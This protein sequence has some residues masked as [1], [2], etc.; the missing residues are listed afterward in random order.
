MSSESKRLDRKLLTVSQVAEILDVPEGY[1]RRLM[2]ERRLSF[3]KFGEGRSARVKIDQAD[4]DA[5][6]AQGRVSA[7]GAAS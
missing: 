2:Y 6:I 3:I 1:V 7:T 5:F 4:L